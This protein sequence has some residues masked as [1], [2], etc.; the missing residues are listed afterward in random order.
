MFIVKSVIF[1][2]GQPHEIDP[3]VKKQKNIRCIILY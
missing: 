1:I 2:I 3:I